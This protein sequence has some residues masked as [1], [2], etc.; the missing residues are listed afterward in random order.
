MHSSAEHR[1]RYP[2]AVGALVIGEVLLVGLV[3]F[4]HDFQFRDHVTIFRSCTLSG[5]CS[6]P[7]LSEITFARR[8]RQ[9][10]NAEGFD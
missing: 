7:L 10:Q 2:G 1:P 9:R 4:I 8:S 5:S 6:A 3:C